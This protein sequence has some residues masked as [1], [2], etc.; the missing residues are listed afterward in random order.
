MTV[1]DFALLSA[2]MNHT[3][4]SR[5]FIRAKA[6]RRAPF[7]FTISAAAPGVTIAGDGKPEGD[8]AL[9]MPVPATDFQI[10]PGFEIV[11][12]P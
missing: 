4:V 1:I 12:H 8:C 9:G 2:R 3:F 10:K 5:T 6:R 7:P 11:T